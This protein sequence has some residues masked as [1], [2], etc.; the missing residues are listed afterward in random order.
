MVDGEGVAG[1]RWV[2]GCGDQGS[3][4]EGL[5]DREM[6][7]LRVVNKGLQLR[8]WHVG[9]WGCE[10]L[11]ERLACLGELLSLLRDVSLELTSLEGI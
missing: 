1:R 8:G 10:V 11:L 4:C 6:E 3:G 9:L 2:W 5:E 7:L